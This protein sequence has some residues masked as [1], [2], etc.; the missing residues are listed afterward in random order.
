M[1]VLTVLVVALVFAYSNCLDNEFQL[2]DSY[3]LVENPWIRSLS[4]IPRFFSDPQTLTSLKANADYRPILQITYAVNYAI[5]RYRPWSWHLVNLALHLGVSLGV[6]FLGRRLFG[7]RRIAELSWISS[8]DGNRAAA[9]GALVFAVHPISSGCVNYVWARSSLL[10]TAFLVPATVAYLGNLRDPR[11]L[12]GLLPSLGLYLLALFTKVEAICFFGVV[13]LAEFL[14]GSRGDDSPLW[15]RLLSRKAW[16][17]ILPFALVS[18]A[19]FGL[20]QALLPG[21]VA[22]LRHDAEVTSYFYFLTQLRVWWHYLGRFLAPVAL[23]ADDKSYPV[24]ISLF[25]PV[26]L[27]S[28]FAWMVVLALVS[29]ALKAAGPVAFVALCFFVHLSPHSSFSPLAEMVNEHRPYLATTGVSLLAAVGTMVLVRR[30]CVR[31]G[32]VFGTIVVGFAITFG[33]ITHA[34]NR[35]WRDAL[36]LWGD[37]VLKAPLST[38]GQ[39]NYGLAVMARGRFD[40]ATYRFREAIRLAPSYWLAY[41]N[42]GISLSHQGDDHGAQRAYD[43]GVRL[44]PA[45]PQGYYW[46]GLYRVQRKEIGPAIVDFRAAEDRD[47]RFVAALAQLAEC[48][49]L[50]GR[51]QEAS[52]VVKKGMAL[53]PERFRSIR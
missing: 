40:E 16:L 13:V 21:W 8:E 6:F 52:V 3:G 35:D 20:Y 26:V 32:T 36:T 15:S 39:M 10:V 31:P 48:L 42:L 24:S 5:S 12:R 18:V 37:V 53:D 34:R 22:S 33:A 27:H 19:Y 23:V 25:E 9:A 17:K 30:L 46:R 38:R 47:D 7:S 45:D 2:D 4:N 41:I 28:L 43:D 29:R 44:N 11:G 51:K 50:Q 49:L 14:L 1:A